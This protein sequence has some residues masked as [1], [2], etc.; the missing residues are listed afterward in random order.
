MRVKVWV[1]VQQ[2]MEF[3]VSLADVM[4]TIAHL[5]ESDRLP[6]ILDCINS[7]WRVL[8]EI[9]ETQ[10]TAMN[11]KQRDTI[12]T[13]LHAQAERYVKPNA[14]AQP[15]LPPTTETKS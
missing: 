10:I 3:D 7:V 14:E 2:E 15:P 13:A 5:G 8:T 11:D 12:A 6:M 1:D 4:S 9:P